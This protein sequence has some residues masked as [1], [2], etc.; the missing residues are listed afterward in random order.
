ME[1]IPLSIEIP[2]E[3]YQRMVVIS[4][5]CDFTVPEIGSL[6][7]RMAVEDLESGL[8]HLQQ[9]RDNDPAWNGEAVDLRRQH[10]KER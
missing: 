1:M 10:E 5:L 2:E 8:R 3:L 6:G 7:M 4:Q 9:L